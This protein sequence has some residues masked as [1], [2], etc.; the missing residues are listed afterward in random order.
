MVTSKKETPQAESGF[1]KENLRSERRTKFLED[2]IDTK[3][4]E[5]L[6]LIGPL[7]R[8]AKIS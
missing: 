6:D 7:S 4:R 1:G 8:M 2:G 3:R 5:S